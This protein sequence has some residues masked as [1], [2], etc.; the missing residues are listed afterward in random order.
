MNSADAYADILR[1]FELLEPSI[2]VVWVLEA[3]PEEHKEQVFVMPLEPGTASLYA[4]YGI[5]AADKM[6][7]VHP[8]TAFRLF[9]MLEQNNMPYTTERPWLT[10]EATNDQP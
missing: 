6:V 5:K 9:R 4:K 2:L 7:I 1:A 8:D 10:K 3:V